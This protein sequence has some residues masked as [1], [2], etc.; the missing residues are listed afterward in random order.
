MLRI[1]FLYLSKA[2][3]ANNLITHWGFAWRAASRFVAGEDNEQALIIASQLNSEGFRIALDPL[4]EHTN[5][6]DAAIAAAD[7]I[8]GL[9]DKINQNSVNSYVSIKLSQLGLL[10]DE[11]LCYSLLKKILLKAK[12]TGLFIRVDMEDSSI[13]NKTIETTIWMRSIYQNVGVVIQSYLYRSE[14]DVFTVLKELI[15][16]RMVKGA[17][18]EPKEVAYPNKADV[19]ENFDKLSQIILKS[20]LK[21]QKL[22]S[23]PLHPPILA[24]ATHDEPR[25]KNLLDFARI[26]GFEKLDFEI[27]MLYGIRRD[28]QEKYLDLGYP[29]RIYIPY[30]THW[31]PYF[32]RRLAERPANVWFFLSNIFK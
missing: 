24:I 2:K 25:I 3:W 9:L 14:S 4:G 7:E 16:V 31:Y 10:F 1:L 20:N 29:V 22:D 28:L 18:N 19:N 32:M 21:F 12:E 6:T 17:Y 23:S 8:V 13:T 5:T 30:G 26:N 15:P 11:T 27:Q